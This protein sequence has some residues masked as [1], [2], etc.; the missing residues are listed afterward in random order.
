MAGRVCK[1]CQ[2]LTSS[3]LYAGIMNRIKFGTNENIPLAYHGVG[4]LMAVTW[5]K[6]D[7]NK[8]LRMLK[9]NDS[10][11][12]LVKASTLEDH[13][14]WV[15]AITS[16][17]SWLS[18]AVGPGYHKQKGQLRGFTGTSGFET[19]SQDQDTHPAIREGS[20]QVV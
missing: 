11:K 1:N 2:E 4:G 17:G 13:K 18:Q 9:L 8:Q 5:W 3:T 12:L 16:S 20:R 7:Q 10:Q 14:Q 15:L 6:M 19:S